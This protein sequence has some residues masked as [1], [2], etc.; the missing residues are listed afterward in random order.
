MVKL[1]I[2]DGP[3]LNETAAQKFLTLD[4]PLAMAPSSLE[5]RYHIYCQGYKIADRIFKS[6]NFDWPSVYGNIYHFT[7]R[8]NK[9][10]MIAELKRIL[11][12]VEEVE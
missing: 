9:K 5:S 1:W 2:C 3:L 10:E 7:A 4:C 12:D 11:G 8:M 6:G